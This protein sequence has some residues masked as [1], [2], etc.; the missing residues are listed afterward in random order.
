MFD[1]KNVKFYIFVSLLAFLFASCETDVEK[2]IF[3]GVGTVDAA[4]SSTILTKDLASGDNGKFSIT[5]Y[6]GKGKE[7]AEVPITITDASGKFSLAS[8]KVAF[9]AGEN[10]AKVD[11]L[12]T[13]ANLTPGKTYSIKLTLDDNY[14]SAAKQGTL[15]ITSRM[16]LEYEL[17]GKGHFTSTFFEA[18]WDQPVYK[19]KGVQGFYR[20][21]DCYTK[22]FNIDFN[23]GVDGLVDITGFGNQQT[24]YVDSDYGMIRAKCVSSTNADN[25]IKFQLNF[26]VAAGSFGKY[27]ET[28][29]LPS[30]N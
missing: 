1:M 30:A 12:Y 4:F 28:L 26:N 15:T 20:L 6:R 11:I 14:L 16:K 10:V 13:Y 19:A 3:K 7:A 29:V 5:V 27:W 21:P 9:A 24:G 23:L 17:I 2:T 18:D 22:G 8:T 25:T